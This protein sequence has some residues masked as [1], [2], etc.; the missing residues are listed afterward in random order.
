MTKPASARTPTRLLSALFAASILSGAAQAQDLVIHAGRLIDGLSS[1]P[2]EQISILVTKDRITGVEPGFVSPAG[3]KVIDLSKTT[4][5][6]GLIDAHTHVTSLSRTGNGIAKTMTNSPLDTVLAGTVNVGK[7]LRSGVTTVRDLGGLYGTDIAL[8]K[9]IEAGEVA[10][11]RMWV[12]GEAIGPTGGHNDWSH[13]YAEDVS[14][15][16]WGAGIADGPD[17]V[18]KLAR[19]EHKLGATVIKIMPSGGVVSQGDDPKAQL[20]SDAEIQAAVDTARALGLKIAAHGHGKGAID[21]AVRAGVDS[22]EHGTYADAE[23]W[24]LMKAR[25]TYFVPTLLTTETLR[26]AALNRPE[27]LNPSTVAKVLAMGSSL[28]KLTNAHAAGVKIALG[29]DTGLGEN[30]KEAALMV[31]AGMSP[32]EVIASATTNAA[33]LIGS[34]EIG[35]I[36]TGRYADIVAVAGDP[37]SDITELER[38]R[39]VMKGGKIY[40]SDGVAVPV[41]LVNP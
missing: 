17:A 12:A 3:A 13:G 16:D 22:I 14:R 34:K 4:V 8:K 5:L 38:V 1:K 32:A 41:E 21:A 27:T 30:L 2:R 25:G 20:M 19:T 29:S 40:K 35:A 24:K 39:F 26:D 7:I 28:T 15:R 10:G 31:K 37:L 33:D 6:P 9:A 11:P 18:A 36:E 23:S